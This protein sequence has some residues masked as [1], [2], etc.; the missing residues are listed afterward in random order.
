MEYV[1]CVS[2]CARVQLLV[3]IPA[4]HRNESDD[5]LCGS[6]T[7]QNNDKKCKKKRFDEHHSYRQLLHDQHVE[8]ELCHVFQILF[9]DGLLFVIFFRRLFR[10]PLLAW[11]F[12][13]RGSVL[14]LFQKLKSIPSSCVLLRHVVFCRHVRSSSRPQSAALSAIVC[15]C[16][17]SFDLSCMVAMKSQTPQSLRD[18]PWSRRLSRHTGCRSHL[19]AMELYHHLLLLF[20]LLRSGVFPISTP[21]VA[22][23][24][25]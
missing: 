13:Q 3:F 11:R 14:R 16:F 9:C 1:V 17:G 12:S 19:S 8:D 6:S 18:K 24:W 21:S 7:S 20:L 23:F 22:V 10:F 5:N 2:N 4:V 25:W 15:W